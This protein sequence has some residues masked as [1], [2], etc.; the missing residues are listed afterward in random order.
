MRLD[1]LIA[2]TTGLSRK[3]A[4][5]AIADGQI[6]VEGI[7]R[8]KGNTQISHQHTALFN[9]QRLNIPRPRYL[10][11]HKPAGYICSTQDPQ[12]E[13]VLNLIDFDDRV[14]LHIVGRLDLDT[15]GL[16]LLTSD[17]QWSHRVASPQKKC[18]KI[19]QALLANPI[20]TTAIQQL[21]SG[22]KLKGDTKQTLPAVVKTINKY[23]IQLA[24]IEGR[25]H[26]VKRMLA[27]VD[28]HVLSLHRIQVG[29][30]QLD[31]RLAAGEYRPLTP[32]EI[33][34]IR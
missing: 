17:G 7:S 13:S 2:H 19:Y 22:V 9:G 8:V 31:D 20:T 6:T 1:Y 28:N 16:L 23:T 11:L 21:Q 12:H 30:I 29:D 18:A 32:A 5:K 24:I 15:T 4:K 26:Q 33:E 25:Y 27:A 14:D 34:S 3:Q 10:M